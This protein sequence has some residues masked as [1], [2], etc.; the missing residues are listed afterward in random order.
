MKILLIEDDPNKQR[1]IRDFLDDYFDSNCSIIERRSFQSGYQ[2]LLENQYELLLLDMSMPTFDIEQGESGGRSRP[3]AGKDILM[4]LK[5]KKIILPVIVITQ[6][7]RFGER[8][9]Y[10]TLN[11][12]EEELKNKF[13]ANYLKTVYYQSTSNEW[14]KLLKEVL[15]EIRGN[16]NESNY[17]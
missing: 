9:N 14:K 10:I 13:S 7:V 17:Y 2:E 4:R 12:L 11:E 3:Y 1:E 6:F 15:D 16:I 8:S 5:S